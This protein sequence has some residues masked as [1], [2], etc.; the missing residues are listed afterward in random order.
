M[1][2]TLFIAVILTLITPP[3]LADNE[4]TSWQPILLNRTAA[5]GPAELAVIV[6]RGDPLSIRIGNYYQKRRAIP[7]Q[8]MIYIAFKPGR[9][10]MPKEEFETLKAAVDAQTPASVQAYA[11]TWIAPYRVGC[12]SITT[13]FAAGFDPEY[14]AQGCKLTR[15]SPYFNS[16]SKKPYQDYGI[17]PTMSIAAANFR[18][19]K[20]LI[21]RG[22]ASDT[23]FPTGTAY[24]LQTSDKNR[25]VRINAERQ[26]PEQIS[27]Q[28]QLKLLKKDYLTDKKDILF[29][30]TG[31]AKVPRITTNH[32]L[33]GAIA[34]HL[35]SAGG[36]LTGSGQMSALRWLEAG[37]TGSYGAVVEPCNFPTKFPV[38]EIAIAHYLSG[39]SLIESYWKS[40][41]MP[42]QGIFIGEPLAKPF[43][44]FRTT[45][46]DSQLTVYSPTLPSGH[47]QLYG[48]TTPKGPFTL[49]AA[50]STLIPS[51]HQLQFNVNKPYPFYLIKRK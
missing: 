18:S 1:Q 49:S 9:G 7:E 38:P 28:V 6:N 40:V 33:P 39:E 17:R 48:A 50:A 15:T 26:Y 4:P 51:P 32:Y 24:L 16:T 13:A 37:A 20:E 45:S 41:T 11:L 35:T 5:I 34:D 42:G 2:R 8:N 27:P 31:L 30:F 47:Y 3:L 21:D 25:T 14:C 19:A 29:Y 22:V 36:V 12:M 23:T 10:V 46:N 44:G 43:G